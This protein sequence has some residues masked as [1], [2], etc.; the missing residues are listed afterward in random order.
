MH[1]YT[2]PNT[3]DTTLVSLIFILDVFMLLF[4][5]A[6]FCLDFAHF[7]SLICKALKCTGV[8]KLHINMRY[9]YD[10][11]AGVM[12]IMAQWHWWWMIW[13]WCQWWGEQCWWLGRA[14][15]GLDDQISGKFVQPGPVPVFVNVPTPVFPQ[16]FLTWPSTY[17]SQLSPQYFSQ[18]PSW[19]FSQ[20]SHNY[21][22]QVY[23][24]L[25][26]WPA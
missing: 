26:L 9:D 14:Q 22:S 3:T 23:I 1:K 10:N 17:F 8:Q 24:T 5:Q 18:W 4:G 11:S 2:S 13:C 19:Y 7:F 6:I 20:R 12:T 15:V 25:S 21:L 16:Y